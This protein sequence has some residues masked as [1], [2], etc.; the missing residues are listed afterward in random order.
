MNPQISE[1][2]FEEICGFFDFFDIVFR[3][4]YWSP[5]MNGSYITLEE[6]GSALNACYSDYYFENPYPFDSTE[7]VTVLWRRGFKPLV[8]FTRIE[9][10]ALT[11]TYGDPDYSQM[12]LDA[13]CFQ[14]YELEAQEVITDTVSNSF[15]TFTA[16]H[17]YDYNADM[18][19]EKKAILWT[20]LRNARSVGALQ[21]F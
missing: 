13:Y 6:K 17:E 19:I 4:D 1:E 9:E 21:N 7:D 8:Q 10:W 5:N 3:K 11:G 16:E 14:T 12:P 18:I 2:T 20:N 15:L